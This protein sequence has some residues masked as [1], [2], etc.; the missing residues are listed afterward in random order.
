MLKKGLTAQINEKNEKEEGIV[1]GSGINKPNMSQAH[2]TSA[3]AQAQL[4]LLLAQLLG[5]FNN[6][7]NSGNRSDFSLYS[8]STNN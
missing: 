4:G 8:N 5:N 7:C 6:K 3:Q 1:F 2:L